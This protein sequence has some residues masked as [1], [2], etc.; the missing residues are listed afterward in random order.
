MQTILSLSQASSS[1]P[2]NWRANLPLACSTVHLS[3]ARKT[4]R[5]TDRQTDR[6]CVGWWR[7]NLSLRLRKQPDTLPTNPN[8]LRAAVY[9]SAR[10][11]ARILVVL[12]LCCFCL[13]SFDSLTECLL[14]FSSSSEP[15]SVS[16]FCMCWEAL[17]PQWY[18]LAEATSLTIASNKTPDDTSH[19]S[20]HGYVNTKES[21]QEESQFSR[22]HLQG[23]PFFAFCSVS[24]TNGHWSDAGGIQQFWLVSF[25]S[26]GPFGP[27]RNAYFPLLCEISNT[28]NMRANAWM[29]QRQKSSQRGEEA[30]G[31]TNI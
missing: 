5:P 20:K 27:C 7:T 30:L 12:A 2:L 15:L 9:I 22:R 10:P 28:I 29:Q 25:P 1:C 6:Q 18:Q 23:G 14:L 13:S 17:A 21:P 11:S 16:A 19:R 3:V 4:D 31:W 26:C 8:S 24:A